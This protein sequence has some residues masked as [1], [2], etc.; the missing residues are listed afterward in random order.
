MKNTRRVETA[1]G[2]SLSRYSELKQMLVER[3]RDELRLQLG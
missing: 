2:T 3:R 1:V